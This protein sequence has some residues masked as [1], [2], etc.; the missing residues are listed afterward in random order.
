MKLV[1]IVYGNAIDPDVSEALEELGLTSYTKWREVFGKGATSGPH[2]GDHV[3]PG[4]NSMLMIV[5]DDDQLAPLMEAF[6][7]LKERFAHEGLK[8]YSLP[9]EQAL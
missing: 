2:L 1:F 8:L 5:L 7:P 3:W 6:R 9:V 4:V